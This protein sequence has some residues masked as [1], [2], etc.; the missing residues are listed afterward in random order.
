MNPSASAP[1]PGRVGI[2]G[3]RCSTVDAVLLVDLTAHTDLG[4]AARSDDMADAVDIAELVGTARSIVTGPPRALL[5]TLAVHC[6][7]ALLARFSSVDRI[8]VRISKPDPAGLDAEAEI[9]EVTL[10]R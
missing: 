6:A 5:E 4:P 9:V 1:V 10:D 3:I 2:R 7:E 8:E